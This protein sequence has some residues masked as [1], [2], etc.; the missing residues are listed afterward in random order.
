MKI[1]PEEGMRGFVI[2]A[3]TK[4][5]EMLLAEYTLGTTLTVYNAQLIAPGI[6]TEIS[7]SVLTK[8]QVERSVETVN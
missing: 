8:E 6:A 4:E 1:R 2:E 7:I 5:E 3:E